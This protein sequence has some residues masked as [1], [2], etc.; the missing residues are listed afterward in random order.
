MG[1]IASLFVPCF[2]LSVVSLYIALGGRVLIYYGLAIVAYLIIRYAFKNEPPRLRA[3]VGER[4][5]ND[6]V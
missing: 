5:K 2:M 4:D 6:A 3:T 1:R